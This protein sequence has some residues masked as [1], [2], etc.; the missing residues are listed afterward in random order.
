MERVGTSKMEMNSEKKEWQNLIRARVEAMNVF[1]VHCSLF[2]ALDRLWK[3]KTT[4]KRQRLK[5]H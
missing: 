4:E 1:N 5:K 2:N 3:K